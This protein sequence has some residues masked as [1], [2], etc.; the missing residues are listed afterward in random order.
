M[1]W[2]RGYE[3]TAA[4][5]EITI[6][7]LTA[8]TEEFLQRELSDRRDIDKKNEVSDWSKFILPCH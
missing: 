3:K 7:V 5:G 1:D 2:E 4:Q 6:Y 8:F